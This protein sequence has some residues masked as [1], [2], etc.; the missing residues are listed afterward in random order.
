ML[1]VQAAPV[2]RP[3]V[4]LLTVILLYST[5]ISLLMMY[6]LMFPYHYHRTLRILRKL[7]PKEI[8]RLL[9]TCVAFA[10]WTLWIFIR[11]IHVELAPEARG[12]QEDEP[13]GRGRGSR[14]IGDD[15]P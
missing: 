14:D 13:G 2:A 15:E 5:F 4:P 7:T 3:D 10:L 11:A 9:R 1:L 12:Q 6:S 8:A